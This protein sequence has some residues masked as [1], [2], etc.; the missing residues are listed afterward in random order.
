M[1]CGPTW[2]IGSNIFTTTHDDKRGDAKRQCRPRPG[3]R[4]S[5]IYRSIPDFVRFDRPR[6]CAASVHDLRRVDV[7]LAE[8]D[9]QRHTNQQ[10][11]HPT[12]QDTPG[13]YQTLAATAPARSSARGPGSVLECIAHP[14]SSAATRIRLRYLCAI[15][16]SSDR[17]VSRRINE[18]GPPSYRRKLWMSEKRDVP[19][20]GKLSSQPQSPGGNRG[21]GTP[22]MLK[23]YHDEGGGAGR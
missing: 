23:V 18:G 4:G 9:R 11:A 6:S 3:H 13:T 15:G 5:A 12:D 22:P 1:P 8:R 14:V 19:F 21:K 17:S 7:D 16:A 2:L 20:L 10:G